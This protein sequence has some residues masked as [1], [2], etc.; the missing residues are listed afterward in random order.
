MR[1]ELKINI[2]CCLLLFVGGRAQKK[3]EDREEKG[4]KEGGE[5]G[6]GYCVF[7]PPLLPLSLTDDVGFQSTAKEGTCTRDLAA[8]L[9][10]SYAESKQNITLCTFFPHTLWAIN[11][12]PVRL[13]VNK[14]QKAK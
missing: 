13:N 2:C 4:H 11:S 5:G 7:N 8:D 9:R 1:V 3:G 14:T 12:W 6:G 10:K